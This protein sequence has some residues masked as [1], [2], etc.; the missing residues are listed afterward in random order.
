MIG[1]RRWG[2]RELQS[3]N[4]PQK[5]VAHSSKGTGGRRRRVSGAS[6][7]ITAFVCGVTPL[8][9]WVCVATSRT[10]VRLHD[11]EH[12]RKPP[13]AWVCSFPE[14]GLQA[15]DP[16][17]SSSPMR[18]LGRLALSSS[19]RTTGSDL[20][21]IRGRNRCG[22]ATTRASTPI[23]DVAG[24]DVLHRRRRRRFPSRVAEYWRLDWCS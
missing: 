12:R 20:L 6:T 2:R 1:G 8:A 5:H 16:A 9:R 23:L 21:G 22:A 19:T 4:R 17:V 24:T 7:R 14:V 18:R 10:A 3:R 13:K 11:F 15:V